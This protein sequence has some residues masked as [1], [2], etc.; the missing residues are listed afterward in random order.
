[1][2]QENRVRIR[3]GVGTDEVDLA[4]AVAGLDDLNAVGARDDIDLA[5]VVE[6]ARCRR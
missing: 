2:I 6:I 4:V 1:L 3:V 5:V